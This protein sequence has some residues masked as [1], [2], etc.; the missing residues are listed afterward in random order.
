MRPSD[1]VHLH[2]LLNHFPTVGMIVG[3]GVFLLAL[4]KKSVDLRRGGLAVLFVIA[5]LSLPTYMTG[6]SAQ[7][8]LK[9]MPG[10]SQGVIDLHQRSALMA[11]IFMEATGVAAWYGLWYSRRRA[12]SHRGNTAL[13][14]LLGALT[15]GLMSSAANVGGE[16]RHPE[17]LSG[18]E[19]IPATEGL[20]AP[21]WLA[22]DFITKYQYSHP[23]AWKTLETIHFMGLCLLF[24]VVLVG[25]MRLLGWM[26]NAPLE[27][28]HRM[29][30]WGIWGFVAN[31]VTGM[32]FFIGQAFQYIENPA[33]HWKMLCILLAGGNV[34]YL[35]WHDE[36]WDLGPGDAAPAFVKVL[37][38][39][40]IV[41]WVGVIYFGRMLP[42]LGDAF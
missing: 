22:S 41:L 6:Y 23:W 36:V 8:S 11:L 4:V 10:V 13:V 25:N 27:G 20:L 14:L 21:H 40:Q 7:K 1:L 26:R 34:L 37:A 19:A 42:Y 18:P 15:I 9:G 17:I 33:F 30:P 31:A 24:G 28:F 2:L 16:I 3:F 5:L 12:W 32:M 29:L 35:T 38:A 39:S